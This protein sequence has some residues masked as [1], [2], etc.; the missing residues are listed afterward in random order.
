MKVLL[1]DPSLFTAPYDAGLTEGLLFA[2]VD[3]IWATRPIRKGDQPE[4]SPAHVDAFFYRWID[5]AT[6]VPEALRPILKGVAHLWGMTQLVF[7]VWQIKPAV[8]HFQWVVLPPVDI[9]AIALI[10]LF[11]PVVLTVHDTVPFNGEHISL[12]QNLAFDLPVRLVDHVIVHTEAAAA[13]LAK[14]GVLKSK[15]SVIKHGPLSLNVEPDDIFA[16]SLSVHEGRKIFVLFG[17]IKHYKGLDI[18]V[19]AVG[20]L[21]DSTRVNIR[22]VV[23]GRPRMDL[24]SITSRID[25]LG[26]QKNFDIRLG[27]LS[28]PEIAAL[29]SRADCFLFPY[30]QIDASGVYF[31][32]KSYGKWMIASRVGVFVEDIQEGEDGSLFAVENSEEFAQKITQFLK[33][34]KSKKVPRASPGNWNQIGLQTR[35][36]YTQLI[37]R[38]LQR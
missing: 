2:G 37:K 18:L 16:N 3:P 1:V 15:I 27:R 20:K 23:A 17:E 38:S 4:V 36:V 19:E 9:F 33:D 11:R 29:F 22:I 24:Q 6:R 5:A 35:S 26:V 32:A 7:R 8:V 14:R 31:L 28:E 13:R 34:Q 30:R 10:R 25:A 21:D 12:F